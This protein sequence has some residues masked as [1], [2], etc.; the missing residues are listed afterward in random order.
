MPPAL[1]RNDRQHTPAHRRE[2]GPED[3]HDPPDRTPERPRGSSP[4]STACAD[5][6]RRQGP[7]AAARSGYARALTPTPHIGASTTRRRRSKK[8]QPGLDRP[9]SFRNDLRKRRRPVASSTFARRRLLILPL[10][11]LWRGLARSVR[12]PPPGAGAAGGPSWCGPRYSGR[13]GMRLLV[14]GENL[15]ELAP[16][17]GD[18]VA[19]ACRDGSAPSAPVCER[20]YN[21]RRRP[22]T[23]A[24]G[25][26]PPSRSCRWRFTGRRPP[27]SPRRGG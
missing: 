27:G 15:F 13:P 22:R 5:R 26:R 19:S 4:S 6:R 11:K 10:D 8:G 20:A 7:P 18:L 23:S 1:R 9:R 12:A 21:N 3:A 24:L 14:D 25:A 2:T 16:I 17:L